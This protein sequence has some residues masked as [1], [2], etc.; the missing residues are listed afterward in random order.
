MFRQNGAMHGARLMGQGHR[1]GHFVQNI[2]WDT[3]PRCTMLSGRVVAVTLRQT[4]CL[5]IASDIA[6]D[7]DTGVKHHVYTLPL[8]IWTHGL[9]SWT[10][11]MLNMSRPF[12]RGRSDVGR[13][14]HVT[15][16]CGSLR[17]RT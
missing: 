2:E 17:S 5:D 14:L 16:V 6:S 12:D 1:K 11:D 4:F 10:C 3:F 13:R 15:P 9:A 8:G 7:I